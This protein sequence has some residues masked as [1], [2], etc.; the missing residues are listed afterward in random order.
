MKTKMNLFIF[1][2]FV[3]AMFFNNAFS[4]KQESNRMKYKTIKSQTILL[5]EAKENLKFQG[6]SRIDGKGKNIN[7]SKKKVKIWKNATLTI[8][9]GTII[10]GGK[11]RL[12]DNTSTLV[13]ENVTWKLDSPYI[14]RLGKIIFVNNVTIEKQGSNHTSFAFVSEKTSVIKRNSTLTISK[15][16][17]KIFPPQK[18][19]LS[20]IKFEGKSSTIILDNLY[21]FFSKVHLKDGTMD[22]KNKVIFVK[23]DKLFGQ[24]KTP[25]L[26][27]TLLDS[28]IIHEN[29]KVIFEGDVRFPEKNFPYM[30]KLS[31]N[32]LYL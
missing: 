19:S 10:N 18:N 7:F 5:N 8:K 26:D 29:A 20:N 30:K 22:I 1:I 12:F 27:L 25:I 6:K 23:E 28:F 14:L 9:N 17:V 16:N 15:I 2:L 4:M 11:I 3:S 32:W 31:H 13:L 24:N 21:L